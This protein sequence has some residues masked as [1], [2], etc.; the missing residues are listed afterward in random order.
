[1]LKTIGEQRP[2]GKAGQSVVKGLMF[3]RLLREATLLLVF[4]SRPS[5]KR[6]LSE[7]F[8]GPSPSQ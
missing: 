5:I 3:E 8:L 1:M 2:V 6:Q 4:G 7:L